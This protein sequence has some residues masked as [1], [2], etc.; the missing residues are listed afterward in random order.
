MPLPASH[1][2]FSSF[3]SFSW[4]LSSKALVLLV[5]TQ[6]LHFRR[7]RQHPLFL[8]GDKGTVYQTSTFFWTP[9][10]LCNF[11]AAIPLFSAGLPSRTCI[12]LP[13]IIPETIA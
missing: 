12:T 6:I 4:G 9:N 11:N 5:L 1:L 8:A 3:L 7:F 10:F 2:L 13:K